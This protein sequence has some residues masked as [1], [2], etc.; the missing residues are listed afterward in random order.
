MSDNPKTVQIGQGMVTATIRL[1]QLVYSDADERSK[2]IR[3]EGVECEDIAKIIR[4]RIS[5]NHL[6][7]IAESGV[8]HFSELEWAATIDSYGTVL[9]DVQARCGFKPGYNSSVMYDQLMKDAVNI[10]LEWLQAIMDIHKIIKLL[11][12]SNKGHAELLNKLPQMIFNLQSLLAKKKEMEKSFKEQELERGNTP[13]PSDPDSVM[14]WDE[15]AY[16]RYKKHI[17]RFHKIIKSQV[18]D[19]ECDKWALIKPL[20]DKCWELLEYSADKYP[21]IPEIKQPFT[22]SYEP[23]LTVEEDEAQRIFITLEEPQDELHDKIDKLVS[24]RIDQ[25]L[26]TRVT[27]PSGRGLDGH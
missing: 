3:V 14:L 2:P 13:Q 16:K 21:D 12:R 1:L 24:D 17:N 19:K 6:Y 9:I 8:K 22:S 15:D 25:A 5:W 20:T 10:P 7:S 27:S 23:T 26:V 11:Y 4:A 18:F